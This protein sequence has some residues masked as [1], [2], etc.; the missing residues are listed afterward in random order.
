MQIDWSTSIELGSDKASSADFEEQLNKT[1]EFDQSTQTTSNILGG[2]SIP[3]TNDMLKES[4]E[5]FKVE[6]S[7]ARNASFGGS[8]TSFTI[9]VT[10]N[11]DEGIPEI[12]LWRI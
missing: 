9:T 8:D 1:L 4:A 3:I 2:I 10:I 12:S 5:E 7:N 11:D 6:L